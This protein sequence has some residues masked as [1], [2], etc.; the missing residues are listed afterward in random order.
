MRAAAARVLPTAAMALFMFAAGPGQTASSGL[1]AGA[2]RVDITP[3]TDEMPPPFKTVGDRIYVRALVLDDGSRRAVLVIADVLTIATKVVAGLTQR[4]AEIAHVP[5]EN[6]LLGSTHT[7]NAMRVDTTVQGISLPGSAKF[8]DR[9]VAATLKAV[10]QAQANLQPSRAGFATGSAAL[11]ANR[12]QWLPEQHRYIDGVDRTGT[13]PIDRRLDVLKIET[14]AG[15]PIAF[16]LNYGIE[17][18]VAMP[19]DSEISGDV[20]G[21][22]SRYIEDRYDGQAVALFTIGAAGS[23]LYRAK[24]GHPADGPDPHVLVS[25]M[26]T[27]LGEEALATAKDMR[28]AVS[29]VRL[30]GTQRTLQCPGKVTT[31]LNLPNQ[32]AYSADSKL[33]GCTFTDKDAPPVTLRMGLLRIG[34][35][36]IV[37]VD[38]NVTPA[39]WRKLAM[40]SPAADTVLVA[41]TYGPFHYVVDDAAYPLNTYEATASTAKQGCAEQGFVDGALDM[42]ERSR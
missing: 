20:P 27:I 36:A 22:A 19:L 30:Q 24:P 21:A 12:N 37:Q 14:L 1:K 28:M 10:D 7:H 3:T 17:P 38:A 25:A 39:L 41:L 33:P 15:K 35:V 13:E 42:I 9:V 31:P 26:G 34:D 18:V 40:A 23:P 5:A 6:I 11:V 4:I 2:A 32:C 8:V 16:L 29:G